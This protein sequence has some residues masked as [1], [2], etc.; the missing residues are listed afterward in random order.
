M[1]FS[2]GGL[3]HRINA[4]LELLDPNSSAAQLCEPVNWQ[5]SWTQSQARV[6]QA[7]LHAAIACRLKLWRGM[8]RL[9]LV[10]EQTS[11]IEKTRA[12]L[13]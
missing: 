12:E 3:R 1:A 7:R 4:A 2:L 13:A 9:A 5:E 8:A 6:S 11:P 10:R